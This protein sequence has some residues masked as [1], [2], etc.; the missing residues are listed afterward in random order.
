MSENAGAGS[1]S[2][3]DAIKHYENIIFTRSD[4]VA[5]ITLNRPERRNALTIPL[6]EEMHDALDTVE[7]D[8]SIR[9]LVLAGAG[10]AFCAGRDFKE[11]T[12]LTPDRILYYGKLNFEAR[13]RLR[14]LSKPV[15]AR[16]HGPASGGGCAISTDCSD[17][18]IASSSA[19]FSI[20]EVQAGTVPGLPVFTLG[21]ARTLGMLLTGDWI[22]GEQAAQWGLV[23]KCVPDDQ[24]DETVKAVAEQLAAQPAMAMSYTKRATSFLLDLAGY[25]QAEQYLVECRKVLADSKDR[26][27][28][29]MSFL[30][31]R[32]R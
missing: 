25:T 5:T 21:R 12:G 32:R 28:G 8:E 10:T 16:V 3:D 27:E 13:D 9:V 1:I 7:S 2:K 22:G 4:A 18:C 30:E 20:R 31:K 15:I 29:Q 19:R 26:L 6:F 23:Y 24:L 11:S 14:K 17:I